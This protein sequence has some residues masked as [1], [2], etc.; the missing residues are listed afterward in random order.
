MS[1]F[2]ETEK[3]PRGYLFVFSIARRLGIKR[4]ANAKIRKFPATLRKSSGSCVSS[5]WTIDCAEKRRGVVEKSKQ[6]TITLKILLTDEQNAHF[7]RFLLPDFVVFFFFSFF[8]F[9]GERERVSLVALA[10]GQTPPRCIRPRTHPTND[11]RH[12]YVEIRPWE[13]A[14]TSQRSGFTHVLP[15]QDRRVRQ[16]LMQFEIIIVVNSRR[17]VLYQLL[18]YHVL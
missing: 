5:L 6:T 1:G 15:V 11:F 16:L 7:P 9:R 3:P 2:P 8:L 13:R 14:S 4:R 10:D 12:D 17:P 18:S